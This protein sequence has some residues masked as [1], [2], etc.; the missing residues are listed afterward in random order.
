MSANRHSLTDTTDM[1]ILH[2]LGHPLTRPEVAALLGISRSRVHQIEN[3][4]L[5]KI[6]AA[7]VEMP[8][9]VAAAEKGG[10]QP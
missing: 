5:A 6:R 7:L 10:G 4:A 3:L 1:R 2:A 9:A 8:E